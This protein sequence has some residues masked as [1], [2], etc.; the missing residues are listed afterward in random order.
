MKSSIIEHIRLS[1]TLTPFDVCWIPN[2]TRFVLLGGT[3][4][5]YGA[6]DVYKMYKGE[7]QNISRFE[8]SKPIRCGSFGATPL[9]SR[10][11][12]FGD[13]GGYLNL[14][15]P[16]RPSRPLFNAHA[17]TGILHALSACGPANSSGAPEVAT[18]GSDGFVKLWDFRQNDGPVVD[19]E[20]SEDSQA[21]ECW[22]VALGGSFDAYH[23]TLV[24]GYDNGDV[25]MIDLRMGK[26]TWQTNVGGGVVGM[27]FDTL[28]RE[29]NKL[30]VTN[31]D[32]FI[33][34]Y[35]IKTFN[36]QR[37]YPFVKKK[38]HGG[39]VWRV[40]H[41]PDD[42]DVFCTVGGNGDVKLWKYQYPEN[43]VFIDKEAG[44]KYGVAGKIREMTSSTI[45]TQPVCAFDWHPN[46][47]GL[48]VC[49]SFD[50]S[51]SVLYVTNL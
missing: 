36:E 3:P 10:Y 45:S 18:G 31:L 11:I 19:I 32:G 39:T 1:L 20:P 27:E 4:R 51:I 6:F 42:R 50:Q 7:L 8:H 46:K 24:C 5:D 34:V 49:G 25:K 23:R 15:D 21:R 17:H 44:D 37:G 29:L 26:L 35:D 33:S 14:V 43:R 2:S 28:G 16:E 40:R 30:V 9:S 13:A 12:A 38:G 41:L 22:A 47:S 48:A